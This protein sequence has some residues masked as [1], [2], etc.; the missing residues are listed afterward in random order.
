MAMTV[1]RYSER[2]ELWDETAAVSQAVW[3][4]YNQ[5][6]EV[7]E[8]YWGRLFD[9]FPEFQF[10]LYDDQDGV[11][12]EGHT[13]PGAW[14]GTTEGLGEGIDA[15]IA[16]TFEDR[17]AGRRPNVLGVLAAEI[18]PQFQGRGLANRVLDAMADLGR[19]PA[20]PTSSP[21]SARASRTATRSPRSSAM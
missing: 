8:R 13:A 17:E 10:V 3:P 18:R 16:G 6:G 7:L 4:E 2:P 11:L 14:D 1:I 21:R 20:S 19:R 15:M 9:E 12:A 5:H